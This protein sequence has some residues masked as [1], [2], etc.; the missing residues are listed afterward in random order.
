MRCENG[1]WSA[2]PVCLPAPCSQQP[3]HVHNGMRVFFGNQDGDQARYICFPG[4]RL[5]GINGTYLTCSLGHWVGGSPYCEEYY[6]PNPGSISHGKVL[7]KIDNTLIA[8]FESYIKRIKHGHKLVFQCHVGYTLKG[9]GGA[10][11]VDGVWQPPIA[12]SE[13]ICAVAIHPP[14]RNLWKPIRN[15]RL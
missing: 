1:S 6:C 7:K 12:D 11:C 13:E 4:Y 14:F 15:K 3:P 8:P 2:S 5:A 10:T 9:P